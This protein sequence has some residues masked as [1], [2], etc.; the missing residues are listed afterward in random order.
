MVKTMRFEGPVR[1]ITG[2]LS[3]LRLKIVSLQKWQ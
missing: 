2:I 3:S 1:V